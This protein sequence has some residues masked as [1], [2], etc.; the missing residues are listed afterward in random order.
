MLLE[1]QLIGITLEKTGENG[2]TPLPIQPVRQ[3]LEDLSG[4]PQSPSRKRTRQ[5]D[6]ANEEP[7]EDTPHGLKVVK[8]PTS[9]NHQ[10]LGDA[11]PKGLFEKKRTQRVPPRSKKGLKAGWAVRSPCPSARLFDANLEDKAMIKPT[12][13]WLSLVHSTNP[14]SG[15]SKTERTNLTNTATSAEKFGKSFE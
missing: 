11:V 8:T 10:N 15:K 3:N 13:H 2:V 12:T 9:D 4:S 1:V 7:L 5:P 14:P 6:Q